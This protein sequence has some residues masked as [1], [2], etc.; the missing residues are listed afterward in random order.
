MPDKVTKH[1]SAPDWNALVEERL[2]PLHLP[3]KESQEVVAE[4]AAH[5]EDLYD[6]QIQNGLS[7]CAALEK[8]MNEV[9][10]W[11]PLARKLQRAKLKEGMMNAR[12]KQLWLPGLVSLSAAMVFLTILIQISMQ[13]RYLGRSPLSMVLLPWLAM[14]PLCGA[15]GAYLSRRRG[16]YRWARLAAGL[17]PTIVLFVLCSILTMTHLIVPAQPRLWYGSF[18]LILGIILPSAALLLG[19]LPFLS[20]PNQGTRSAAS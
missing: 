13:P 17:F 3:A 14:L 7:E 10:Q 11:R 4:L 6:E 15:A 16:G 9:A 20:P 18:A 2:R 8:V 12:T 19:T 1:C 5:L